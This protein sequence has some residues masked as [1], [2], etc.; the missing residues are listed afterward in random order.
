[1]TCQCKD[2]IIRFSVKQREARTPG[3]HL[4][5]ANRCSSCGLEAMVVTPPSKLNSTGTRK[6]QIAAIGCQSANRPHR[7]ALQ[8]F[9]LTTSQ[10]P[11]PTLLHSTPSHPIFST[12]DHLHRSKPHCRPFLPIYPRPLSKVRDRELSKSRGR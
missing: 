6:Q 5:T 11:C 3:T 7:S 8:E 2:E 9:L 4:P 10:P 12:S 1:M